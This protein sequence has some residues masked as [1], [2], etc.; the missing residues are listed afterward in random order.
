MLSIRSATFSYPHW[1]EVRLAWSRNQAAPAF[2]ARLFDGERQVG[3]GSQRLA[4]PIALWRSLLTSQGVLE[5]DANRLGGLWAAG[6]NLGHLASLLANA[7]EI[8]EATRDP[9]AGR[10]SLPVYTSADTRVSAEAWASFVYGAVASI[11]DQACRF[12]IV[13]SAGKRPPRRAT[14]DQLALPIEIACADSLAEPLRQTTWYLA[15]ETIR[16]FA[17]RL[18]ARPGLLPEPRRG[19]ILIGDGRQASAEEIDRWLHASEGTARLRIVVNADLDFDYASRCPRNAA[20]VLMPRG[21]RNPVDVVRQ[22][23]EEIVHDKP[24]HEAVASA[25]RQL[26]AL[27]RTPPQLLDRLR[28]WRGGPRL[29][30][31]PGVNQWLRLSQELP[32]VSEA[33]RSVY[34]S[35]LGARL[36][37]FWKKLA[38]HSDSPAAGRLRSQLTA[39]QRAGAPFRSGLSRGIDFGFESAGLLPIAEIYAGQRALAPLQETLRADLA[40][41][42]KD[43]DFARALAH[44]QERKVD[45]QL[46]ALAP[47]QP[48]RAVPHDEVLLAG[49]SVRLA[50]HIGQRAKASLIVGEPPALDPL[51]PPLPDETPHDIDIVVYPKDFALLPDQPSV[52]T[53]QL[54][55]FGGTDPVSWD[56]Q[57]P[58]LRP[59]PQ[60]ATRCESVPVRNTRG[61][62]WIEGDRAE[63]RFSIYFRNQLLQSFRLSAAVS[64]ALAQRR[65]AVFIECDFTQTRRFGDLDSLGDRVLCL[66]LNQGTNGT[67]SLMVKG[68]GKAPEAI[69]WDETLLVKRT[70][71]V[72]GA[73]YKAMFGNNASNFKFDAKTLQPL[74]GSPS[75]FDDAV[76]ELALAGRDLYNQLALNNEGRLDLLNA[77]LESEDRTVQIVLH[78]DNY[79]LPWPL[80]YDYFVPA[81]APNQPLS[82]C[83]GITGSGARCNCS[84]DTAPGICLRGFWGLRHVVEQLSAS[85]PPDAGIP[86]LIAPSATM[87]TLGMVRTVADAYTDALP[88]LFPA[89]PTFSTTP[90]PET[91]LLLD[92]LRSPAHRPALFLYVGHQVNAGSEDVPRPELRSSADLAILRLDDIV[93][94]LRRKQVWT[95]PRPLVFVMGCGTGT[96][97]VDTGIS[98]SGG[99]LKLGAIGVLG[100]ECTVSTPIVA[101]IATELVNKLANGRNI[102]TAL[103]ETIWQLAQQGCPVGLAFTYMGRVEAKLP[104]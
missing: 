10:A 78:H 4:G 75:V 81:G 95:S 17:L 14:E 13:A 70:K 1:V 53:V 74:P 90:Y 52:R 20:T 99:L 34:T 79:A 101:H 100:T 35:G 25:R 45:A 65:N 71:A 97:R 43:P 96:T 37:P 21:T 48:P 63:L 59:P 84:P 64:G 5:L 51:L 32:R 66:A 24:L 102:G 23:L 16:D 22:L 26:R 93:R 38:A 18:S 103:K 6:D 77:V 36:T 61:R 11:R 9:S 55:R 39:L 54:A 50:V 82:V 73:L 94:E 27:S 46:L 60:L 69:E 89:A 104:S 2:V 83:R 33:A 31:D 76:R 3:L 85:P 62:G 72:R 91:Q 40:E 29:I 98:L 8:I 87:P 28:Q 42:V 68:Q 58:S 19:L 44:S 41:I 47:G 80:L 57:V 67:H 88:G 86:G 7:G 12:E 30:A 15:N 56:L 49:S 92:V